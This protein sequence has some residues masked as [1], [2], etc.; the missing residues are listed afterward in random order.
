MKKR[1]LDANVLDWANLVASGMTVWDVE[2][3]LGVSHSTVHWNIINRLPR[4][5]VDLFDKCVS[6]FCV[7]K[8]QGGRRSD[9]TVQSTKSN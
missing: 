8:K 7:H 6:V 9:R 4:I 3:Y 1:W 2:R 5:D